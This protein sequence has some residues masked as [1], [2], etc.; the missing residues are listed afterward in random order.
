MK[1]S[2]PRIV[3]RCLKLDVKANSI[4]PNLA[5]YYDDFQRDYKRLHEFF[6]KICQ[7]P[8]TK[9]V[10]TILVDEK[11]NKKEVETPVFVSVEEKIEA[12]KK[13]YPRFFESM[14]SFGNILVKGGTSASSAYGVIYSKYT[15]REFAQFTS[16]KLAFL[17]KDIHDPKTRESKIKSLKL[18]SIP[19]EE[20]ESIAS[21]VLGM[22][23]N[24][25]ADYWQKNLA[26]RCCDPDRKLGQTLRDLLNL[27]AIRPLDVVYCTRVMDMVVQ[28]LKGQHEKA[29]F[30]VNELSNLQNKVSEFNH[31]LLPLVKELASEMRDKEFGFTR[32][33]FTRVPR[34]V[35]KE[36]L[37][38]EEQK[39]KE[40]IKIFSQEKYKP[41]VDAPYKVLTSL[42]RQ[43]NMS[44][45]LDY[46]MKNRLYPLSPNLDADVSMPIGNTS[47]GKFEIYTDNKK[48]FVKIDKFAPIELFPSK[49]FTNVS[50]V[51]RQNPTCFEINYQ[52]VLN[53]VYCKSGPNKGKLET[54]KL[55][56]PVTKIVKQVALQ[57]RNGR[58]SLL[59]STEEKI[60]NENFIIREFF[61][62]AEFKQ[63]LFD[64]M[65][66]KFYVA[67][68]DLNLR[69]PLAFSVIEV[70]KNNFDLPLKCGQ[71]GSGVV[72]ENRFLAEDSKNCDK[73]LA[74]KKKIVECS[75][76]CDELKQC[77]NKISNKEETF[78]ADELV[79]CDSSQKWL[80]QHSKS[81]VLKKTPE[82]P[83]ELL[84]TNRLKLQI[85]IRDLGIE[86]KQYDK[87]ANSDGH[88]NVSELVRVIQAQDS[89][90]SLVSKYKRFHLKSKEMMYDGKSTNRRRANKKQLYVRKLGSLIKK[91]C[92]ESAA[93]G[94]PISVVALEDL[95]SLKQ[96][97]DNSAKEN[98]L[99]RLFSPQMI[100]KSIEEILENTGIA[101]SANV[102]PNGTSKIDCLTGEVGYRSPYD[103][104]C[105]YVKRDGEIVK[106]DADLN[107]A[108]NIGI[109]Y[110]N[111]NLALY[112]FSTKSTKSKKK[113]ILHDDIDED[114]TEEDAIKMGKRQEQMF[115]KLFRV[116]RPYF[117]LDENGQVHVSQKKIKGKELYEGILYYRAGRLLTEVQ[118]LEEQ[119]S[120]EQEVLEKNE[121]VAS[122]N[123][124]ITGSKIKAFQLL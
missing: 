50:V 68:C 21:D 41:I 114:L 86:L 9:I 98:S 7:F 103:K 87:I 117:Y 32:Y 51:A 124:V 120:L 2:D 121:F 44:D 104:S 97:T 85:A 46:R 40:Q 93:Q 47:L 91:A 52:K 112:K 115:L 89:Y 79:L 1:Y 20:W 27:K 72:V 123:P 45:R 111:N 19:L 76:V 57:K 83:K 60:S 29:K 38:E 42:Y 74:L 118:H 34:L 69:N 3:R 28:S 64:L 58:F 67:S 88:S 56:D 94:K 90:F 102:N 12:I 36:V 100:Q 25:L 78:E 63:E 81:V 26:T 30:H 73:I 82:N 92:L 108:V 35:N 101:V 55:S 18:D 99:T 116:K 43:W 22:S 80:N 15:S 65:P 105:L 16:P 39:L 59:V 107:A 66:D 14:L 37:S 71:F 113:D 95:S 11:G 110:V 17:Q 61:R 23:Q 4:D 33:L 6:S 122:N 106:I 24:D 53:P 5:Q 109:C 54:F 77:K 48:V 10:K 62:Y 96:K 8:F 84:K 13:E 49:Q 119:K 75:K 31:P 70:Y